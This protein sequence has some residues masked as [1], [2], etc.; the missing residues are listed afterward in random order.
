MTSNGHVNAIQGAPTKK[1]FPLESNPAED[2]L[3]IEM[4]VNGVRMDNLL[5]S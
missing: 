5:D 3:V 2:L 1:L 4:Q